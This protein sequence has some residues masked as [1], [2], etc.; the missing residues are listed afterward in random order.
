MDVLTEEKEDGGKR[1]K[2][3]LSQLSSGESLSILAL[4]CLARLFCGIIST[5]VLAKWNLWLKI[6][7][8]QLDD[9][10]QAAACMPLAPVRGSS[11]SIA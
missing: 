2:E 9:E 10:I 3:S 4:I 11:L 5:A 6:I 1:L 8:G 7:F